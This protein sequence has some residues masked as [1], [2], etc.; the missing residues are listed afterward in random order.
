MIDPDPPR[1]Y[2]TG[3]VDAWLWWVGLSVTA[4]VLITVL[5]FIGGA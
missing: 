3:S 4:L 2:F 5:F 1:L